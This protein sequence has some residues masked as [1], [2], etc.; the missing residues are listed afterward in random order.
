MKVLVRLLTLVLVLCVAA[1]AAA[2]G[3]SFWMVHHESDRI[4]DLKAETP[5]AVD[6]VLVLGCGVDAQGKPKPMLHDRMA[7]AV[8]LYQ[9]GR[10]DRLLLSGD[11]VSPGY[12]EP[13]AMETFA[14][15][16][17]VPAEALLLDREGVNTDASIRRARDEYGM[18]RVIIVTQA[19][20]LPRALFL[21]ESYGLEA[22][23]VSATLRKYGPKQIIWSAREILARDKDFVRMLR[24]K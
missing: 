11:G 23:G 1:G 21:A 12:D 17:G 19:Y 16:R 20:H 22:C 13:G 2:L 4:L 10:A 3:I 9:S 15:E 8:I 14:L 7:T 24:E 18:K 6:G 5:M